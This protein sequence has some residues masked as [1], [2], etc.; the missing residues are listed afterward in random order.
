MNDVNSASERSISTYRRQ[1][2][3]DFKR[4][5]VRLVTKEKYTFKAAARAVGVSDQAME[6]AHHFPLHVATARP[7]HTEVIAD[8]HYRQVRSDH[9]ERATT[10]PTGAMP[11]DEKATQHPTQSPH[12][13]ADQDSSRS[14][15]PPHA[16]DAVCS[17]GPTH[18]VVRGGLEPTTDD[19]SDRHASFTTPD[20]R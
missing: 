13:T 11:G 5:V 16:I 4:D 12:V 6:P 8:G 17:I 15:D 2:S 7:G 1:Y 20:Y 10:Q 18:Q 14:K 9:H 3:D 19:V